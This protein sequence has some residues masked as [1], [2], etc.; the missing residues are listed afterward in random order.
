MKT[1]KNP[2]LR[3]SSVV[4]SKPQ[5]AAKGGAAHK[6]AAPVKK[7]PV[8]ENQGGKKWV[9]VRVMCVLDHSGCSYMAI[10]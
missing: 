8:F 5:P 4:P 3:Q 6:P 9:V 2:Q 7:P 10:V 1:H